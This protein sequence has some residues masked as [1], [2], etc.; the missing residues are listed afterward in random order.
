MSLIEAHITLALWVLLIGSVGFILNKKICSYIEKNEY[1][2]GNSMKFSLK[3]FAGTCAS[4]D[5]YP[6]AETRRGC[7]C[8]MMNIYFGHLLLSLCWYVYIRG[9]I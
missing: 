6:G 7:D 8:E 4:G 3:S 2:K 5:G 1:N 9:L